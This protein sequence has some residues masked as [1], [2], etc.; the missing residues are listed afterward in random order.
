MVSSLWDQLRKENHNLRNL[1]VQLS[2]IILRN[3]VEQRALLQLHGRLNLSSSTATM[4]PLEIASR[5]R[6]VA[7]LCAHLGRDTA[8]TETAR[9]LESLSVELADAAERLGVAFAISGADDD[10]GT[11]W[12][13]LS[14][15][16]HDRSPGMKSANL[17]ADYDFS[18]C[19]EY[20]AIPTI[21]TRPTIMAITI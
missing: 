12:G 2:T 16:P 5:L 14:R 13:W 9:E 4:S 20:A 6:E 19:A 10:G 15:P 21:R 1:V 11:S 17:S 18:K 8:Q 3:V 7:L